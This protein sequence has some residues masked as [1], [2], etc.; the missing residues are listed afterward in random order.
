MSSYGMQRCKGIALR[1]LLM[2]GCAALLMLSASV[3]AEVRG[4][5]AP[6]P[7]RTDEIVRMYCKDGGQFAACIRRP[8]GECDAI[9]RPL[10]VGCQAEIP[11]DA[12]EAEQAQAFAAC[13]GREFTGKYAHDVVQAPPC[14]TRIN[15]PNAIKSPPPDFAD[16][17]GPHLM[18]P[19]AK[20]Q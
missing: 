7:S 2:G 17:G 5:S 1:A 4:E 20:G 18:P 3:P 6:P 19:Q 14:I 15:P 16:K 13:F 11:A 9:V 8:A 10:V 12:T